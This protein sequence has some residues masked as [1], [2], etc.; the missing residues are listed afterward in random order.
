MSNDSPRPPAHYREFVQDHPDIAAAYQELGKAVRA[1]G[2]LSEREVA[3]VKLA[4][5][6]GAGLEGGT[7]AHVRKALASGVERDSVEQVA[8]LAIP[9]LGFPATMA[10]YSWV[11]DA[12]DKE[13]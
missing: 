12:S 4:L 5:S 10:A 13:A 2:P 1:A 6:I 7:H 8:L 3:L 11:R 9:T